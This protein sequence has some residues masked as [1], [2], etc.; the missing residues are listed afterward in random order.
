MSKLKMAEII[1][2]AVSALFTAARYVIRF[3][4]HMGKLRPKPEPETV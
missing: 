3:F 1:L 4:V 2:L